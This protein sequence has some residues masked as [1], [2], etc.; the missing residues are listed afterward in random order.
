MSR[1]LR[2]VLLAFIPAIAALVLQAQAAEGSLEPL[3]SQ[4][5]WRSVGPFRGGWSTIV[6]G[7]PSQ[8]EVF[9]FGAADGGLWK[10]ADAGLTWKPLFQ[11]AP[12]ISVGALAIAPSQPD[13]IYIGTGQP[14]TRYDIVDGQGVYRSDDG[15]QTWRSLGLSGTRHIGRIWV[16][17]KNPDLVVVAALGH[18]FGPNEERGLFRSSDGGKHWDKVLY[19]D[20]V[21][22]AVDIAAD[23]AN[24]QVLFASTWQAREWPWLA[25]YLPDRGPGS[26]VWKSTDEGQTWSRLNNGL[27]SGD[28][29]RIGLAIAP[30]TNQQRV[31]AVVD[32]KEHKDAGVYRSDDGG[33]SWKKQ[34]GDDLASSYFDRMIVDPKNPDVLYVV[35]RSIARSADG[36]KTF[37]W[38]KGAPGGD[39]YHFLWI[40]PTD[41]NYMA[42]ASDQGT[43]VS[44]DNGKTWSEWYNQATGQFYHVAT[45]NRF[46]YRIY[47]GQQDSGTVET[48]S[49]SDFGEITFRDWHPVGGDER[50]Y[51][52]P[53]TGDPD[54]VYVGG[55]GGHVSRFDTRTGQVQNISPW[56]VAVYGRRE[57]TVQY[58]FNWFYPVVA[59][60]HAAHTLYVGSQYVWKTSD[61]GLHWNI[62]GGKGANLTGMDPKLTTADAKKAHGCDGD[63]LT[64]VD[65]RDCGY[66]S[67]FSIAPSPKDKN[68]IWAGSDDGL[69]NLTRDGGKHWANVTPADMPL[70]GRVN[71]VEASPL[72]PA[73]AYAAVDIHRQD[74]FLPYIFRTHDYGRSWVNVTTGIP[75]SQFV[76]VVRQD[77]VN[78]KLLYAG[79]NSGVFVSFD[80]G[81]H[82][83]ALQLNLPT[84]RV[85]DLT[86]HGDDLIAATQGRALWVLDDV[87]PLRQAS[88]GLLAAGGYLFKPA[89]AVRVRRNE[90]KDTPLPPE[91]PSAQN[92][93]A[94]AVIDYWI[95][96]GLSG[97][98]TLTIYDSHGKQVRRYASDAS[99]PKL[100]TEQY[101]TDQWLS[102]PEALPA[103]PGAHRFIWDLRYPRPPAL[104]YDYSIAAVAG[105][106][107]DVMPEGGLVLPGNYTLVLAAGGQT[108]K[109]SLSVKMDPRVNYDHAEQQALVAQLKFATELEQA[110]GASY[111]AH[112]QLAE[113][114]DKL[115]TLKARLTTPADAELVQNVDALMAKAA[116]L[117]DKAPDHRD[118]GTINGA[119]TNLAVESGD[120][121][122]EPPAQ[123]REVYG[124]YA[125]YLKAA[126]AAWQTLR[127][128]DLAALNAT[129][130]VHGQP[131]I[132]VPGT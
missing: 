34:G 99:L 85:R 59:D 120:G 46:P 114:H 2:L 26:G 56:P 20:A 109:Q 87:T 105:I 64:L 10:T 9:Y 81:D 27:P 113:L 54:I 51:V 44:V 16:D 67:V 91:V 103:G 97:P 101:F 72:D 102:P 37:S 90:S 32:M 75:D 89:E 73:T 30:G 11:Q 50:S 41:T 118:F 117:Q 129:L 80:D 116:L 13:T 65:A 79:T 36:G 42:L 40:N 25:Y 35:N 119:L 74:K 58:H 24:P 69:I 47:S 77:P 110:M 132:A 111:A 60:P 122:R 123:Y 22:G 121:D 1:R 23:P 100:D 66:G 38:F 83:Q 14:E 6:E 125:G 63:T 68:Q 31:Y 17:P 45:D 95:G 84:A 43:S 104:S 28:V 62:L 76:Y 8:P 93:P 52:V 127:D 70:W 12:S 112:Q 71:Q 21:T 78:P 5:Q 82:W 57:T 88:A 86:V 107:G 131:A 124:M 61:G 126:L 106:G 92:P 19:V 29:G 7:V 94:G 130:Q 115:Q 53:D 55:L 18:I 39:D 49:A 108:W 98:V 33:A 4:M 48:E 15:G 3:F 96:Q 128:R